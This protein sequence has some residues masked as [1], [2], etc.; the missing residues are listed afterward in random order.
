VLLLDEPLGALDLQL[1]KQLQ[2]E[3]LALQRRLGITFVYVTHD[4]EEALVMSDRIAVMRQGKIEQIGESVALYERPR[5]R[6]VSQFLGACNLLP[7]TV[8]RRGPTEAMVSTPVGKLRVDFGPQ[9]AAATQRDTFTL[10]IRPEKVCLLHTH[11]SQGG[12]GVTVRIDQRI[13]SGAATH[14]VLRAGTQELLAYTMNTTA[15]GQA[16]EI[17]Q[18]VLA[19]LP[20]A[21]LL[22]LDD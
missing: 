1:R 6:F 8:Q 22:V 11:Q 5:T 7:A 17:G 19:Y 2:V 14:Y 10:A 4:Q 16:F 9:P 12:N 13:Y 21:G 18:E 3:L 15:A 20:P